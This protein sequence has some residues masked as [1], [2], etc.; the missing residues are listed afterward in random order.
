VTTT[1]AAQ[2][3][4]TE[5]RTDFAGELMDEKIPK[6]TPVFRTY[7]MLKKPSITEIDSLRSNRFWISSLVQRSSMSTATTNSAYG[8]RPWNLS[9]LAIRVNVD[10]IRRGGEETMPYGILNLHFSTEV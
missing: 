2:A 1:T 10:Y 4:N 7:V 8:N 6:A 3:V 5:S 9:N